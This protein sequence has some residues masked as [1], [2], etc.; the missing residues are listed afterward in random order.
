MNLHKNLII[1]AQLL[2]E[3]LPISSSTHAWIADFLWKKVHPNAPDIITEP[4]MDLLFLPTFIVLMIFFR[5]HVAHL[6]KTLAS[7]FTTRPRSTKFAQWLMIMIRVSGYILASLVTFSAVFLGLKTLG[8]P[9]GPTQEYQWMLPLVGLAATALLQM[10]VFFA[11]NTQATES[12]ISLKNAVLIGAFQG[13]SAL[14]GISRLS[15]TLVAA[16]WLNV[17]PHRAFEFSTLL[18]ISVFIGNPIKNMILARAPGELFSTAPYIPLV[19]DL[20][21]DSVAVM[22]VCAALSYGGLVLTN[23]LNASKTLW[24]IAPYFFIPMGIIYFSR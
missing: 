21:W 1:A 15:T 16:R 4:F 7:V 9:V 19:R 5:H 8:G 20:T 12:S 23:T 10:S 3:T 18:Q 14:P 17:P 6:V 22:L 13:F 24:K 11:P 2:C